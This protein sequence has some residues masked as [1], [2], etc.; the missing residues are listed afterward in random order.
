MICVN[1]CLCIRYKVSL[2]DQLMQYD[3]EAQETHT[4]EV[5]NYQK[6]DLAQ[7]VYGYAGLAMPCSILATARGVNL[8]CELL[9]RKTCH[10]KELTPQKLIEQ[11]F[12][13]KSAIKLRGL[14]FISALKK[15]LQV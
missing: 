1:L 7:K 8:A 2:L 11:V 6:W 15:G 4:A 14:T 12:L 5:K 13:K 10:A 3:R 9:C